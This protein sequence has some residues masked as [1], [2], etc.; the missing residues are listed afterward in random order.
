MDGR[1]MRPSI[2]DAS[3]DSSTGSMNAFWGDCHVRFRVR[4]RVKFTSI[5]TGARATDASGAVQLKTHAAVVPRRQHLPHSK[6]T[7]IG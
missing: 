1:G 7:R 3:L 6:C 5:K 4:V 2:A